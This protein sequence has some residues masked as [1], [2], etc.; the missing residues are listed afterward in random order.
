MSEAERQ[1]LSLI[2]TR[3]FQRGHFRLASGAE[4]DHYIDCKMVEVF[5]ESA[6]LIGK[7]IVDRTGPRGIDAVGGMETGAIPLAT[8]AAVHFHMAGHEVEGF[9]VRNA[10]KDHG[11]Q[12]LIE[13]NLQPGARVLVVEDVVTSGKSVLKAV[14]SVR[15]A[16]AE[17]V[18]VLALMDRLQGGAETFRRA[19]VPFEAVFTVRDLGVEAG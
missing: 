18:L 12:K 2:R 16:G 9:W 3:A 14:D 11:T 19:G 1:L 5:S 6:F 15:Q 4:S 8:A 17:V 13:G 10:V 7:V